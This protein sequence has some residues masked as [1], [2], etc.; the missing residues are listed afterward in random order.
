MA[1]FL[2]LTPNLKQTVL[3]NQ[4]ALTLASD[5]IAAQNGTTPEEA[6]GLLAK[7][8]L[9]K[10]RTYSPDD[11]DNV[12]HQL[13]QIAEKVEERQTTEIITLEIQRH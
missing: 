9:E 12:L 5:L 3:V 11:I 1:D 6:L 10:V 8:S 7:D 13:N 4:F 2:D